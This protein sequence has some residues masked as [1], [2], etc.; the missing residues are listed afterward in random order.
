[1]RMIWEKY[2]L[3]DRRL[4]ELEAEGLHPRDIADSLNTEYSEEL[5]RTFTED[6]VRNRLKRVPREMLSRYSVTDIMPYFRKYEPIIRNQAPA[7]AKLDW[8]ECLAKLRTGRKK[9]LVLQ[10]LH[11]PFQDDEAIQWAVD[12][13]RASDLVVVNGDYCD[14]YAISRFQKELNIPLEVEIDGMCR[15]NEFLARTF[16]PVPVVVVQSNHH[17]RV[18]KA[19]MFPP[20]LEFLVETDLVEMLA[21]PFA[22]IL[23]MDDWWIQVNDTIFAHAETNSVTEGK[24]VVDTWQW[25]NNWRKYLELRD[26]TT[27]VEAHT[28]RIAV[29]HRLGGKMMEAGAL[30]KAM[31]YTR[32][33]VKYRYPGNTGFAQIVWDNG[34][35]RMNLCREYCREGLT[36]AVL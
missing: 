23:A 12:L 4:V 11:I 5:H 13:G 16:E 19:M 6:Q 33:G 30:C 35:S 32:R 34:A 24:P 7:P 21:K 18:A 27:L 36:R 25:F 26:F 17:W 31:P 3:L 2:P 29:V 22:N 14:M 20:T 28:H 15:V 1:M 10:D 9:A 8:A